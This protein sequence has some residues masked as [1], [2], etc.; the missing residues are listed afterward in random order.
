[1]HAARARLPARVQQGRRRRHRLLPQ[2]R[3]QRAGHAGT[4]AAADVQ[5]D[6]PA[7]GHAQAV[8]RKAGGAGRVAGGRPGCNG[9]SPARRD[10]RRQEHLRS[11]ADQLQEQVRGRL[12]AVPRQEVDRRCRHRAAALRNQATCRAHH[13]HSR[14]LQGAHAG[15]EGAGRSR[16]DG[17]WRDQ[18]RL[19]HGRAPGLRLARRQWLPA[20]PLG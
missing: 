20:A 5:E 15:R 13:H 17:S 19:G 9:E 1:M 18:C 4:D 11:G 8:Q 10:G 6:R 2:A 12:G 14:Q 3:S 16:G 7:P